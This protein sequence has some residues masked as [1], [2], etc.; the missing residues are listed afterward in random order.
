MIAHGVHIIDI[1]AESTRPGAIPLDASSEWNRLHGAIELVMDVV[2]QQPLKPKISI[3]TYHPETAEKALHMGADMINDVSGLG[4]EQMIKLARES[5]REFVAM[6]SVTVPVDPAVGVSSDEDVCEVF[7]KWVRKRQELWLNFGLNLDRIIIDPGI[8]FG[9]NSLQSMQLMRSIESIRKQ[10][11]QRVLIGHSRKRHLRSITNSKSPR[12]DAE[13]IGASLNLCNK[14]VD[15]LRV[16]DVEGHARAY[17]SW[18]HVNHN[19]V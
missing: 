12:L 2:N 17:L 6:H 13:T 10:A 4:S 16:H 19:Q 1:G 8:G 18:L 9:K 7:L 14:R 5:D 3:D 11:G 15:I